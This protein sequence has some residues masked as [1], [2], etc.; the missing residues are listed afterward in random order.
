[1]QIF[2]IL[3]MSFNRL[4]TSRIFKKNLGSGSKT[5]HIMTMIRKIIKT[6]LLALVAIISIS[7]FS[8]FI[9]IYK[10]MIQ[11][12]GTRF[13]RMIVCTE[14][15]DASGNN[16]LLNRITRGYYGIGIGGDL[17]DPV[18]YSHKYLAIKKELD[19]ELAPMKNGHRRGR[20]YEIWPKK[21]KILKE[22]YGID[23]R[24]PH[25]LNPFTYYD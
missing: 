7:I 21:K 3:I 23:W 13:Y 9:F 12:I 14:T 11:I 10:D 20:F 4:C 15:K 18:E 19:K 2:K 8:L 22:K 24:S 6:G 1:M 25:E 17:V 5:E 16:I